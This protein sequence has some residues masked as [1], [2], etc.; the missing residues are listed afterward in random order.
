MTKTR[1]VGFDKV[2][3]GK[4]TLWVVYLNKELKINGSTYFKKSSIVV[5]N[6]PENIYGSEVTVDWK[7]NTIKKV[8]K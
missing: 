7:S 4:Q 1:V 2:S 5:D 8:E 3:D 6:L